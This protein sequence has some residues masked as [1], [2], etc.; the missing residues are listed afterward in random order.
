MF[1]YN[2]VRLLFL[3]TLCLS[4]CS[5][6]HYIHKEVKTSPVLSQHHVGISVYDPAKQKTLAAYQDD[7]YFT[8]AS[9]TKLFSF[10]AALTAL[11]DSIPGLQYQLRD[12]ALVFRGTGDPSLLHPDLPSSAVVDF[13]KNRKEKLLF[14]TALT[15]NPTYGPGW[16]WDD[17]NDYYQ[18]ERSSLPMYGNIARFTSPSGLYVRVQPEF[19]QDSLDLDT[20]VVGLV[21]DRYYNHFRRSLNAL[22]AGLEQDIPV[23]TSNQLTAELL[24]YALQKKVGLTDEEQSGSWKT[25]HSIP[26]DSL[27]RRM[28]LVSDNMMAEQTMLLYAA[29]HG[30]PLNT[31][32]AIEHAQLNILGDLPDRPVWRDGSGLSRYNL[33]TPRTMIALLGKIS[34]KIP[35]DRLFNILPAG[36]SS[37]TLRSMFKG[38]EAFVHAK[39]GSLSNVYCL[40]GYLI[41][42]KGKLLYFSF[43]NNNFVRPTAEIRT[44]VA[45]I[46]T[47]LHDKY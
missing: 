17:Y 8:P 2:S 40:S 34:Q 12:S 39:T 33:F 29:A 37:G 38:Q 43:M 46:L 35:Q 6:S 9:N 19:W 15:D 20:T 5:V 13:L 45:R 27:Y 16:S 41:T 30:L 11:G 32:Q 47:G 24:S 31:T 21:R 4:G 1:S 22:P 36:G 28:M 3:S 18:A 10:Y 25:V 26:S 23:R 44:E 42:K 14:S 7:H